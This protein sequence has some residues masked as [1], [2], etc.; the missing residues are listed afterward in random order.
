MRRVFAPLTAL[1]LASLLGAAA[2]AQVQ[3]QGRITTPKEAFGANYGDD[4]FLANY[5][6]IS[7]YWRTLEQQSPRVK[8][9]VMGKTTEGRDQLMAIITSPETIAISSAIGRSLNASRRPR[10]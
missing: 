2:P 6:Q 1:S 5:Q 8:L 10:T 4:Y 7:S 3:A 9:R